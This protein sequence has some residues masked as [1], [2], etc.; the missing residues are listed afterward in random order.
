[1]KVAN[2]DVAKRTLARLSNCANG[3]SLHGDGAPQRSKR[4]RERQ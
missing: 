3:G 2:E 1:M 4:E